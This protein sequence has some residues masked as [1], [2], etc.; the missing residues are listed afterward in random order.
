LASN[1][2]TSMGGTLAA[3]AITVEEMLDRAALQH[4]VCTYG[5]AIDRH[6]Y[7]LLRSLYHSD[8][9][10]DH[11]PYYSGPASGY[12][13]WLPTMMANWSL[14]SHAMTNMV[15][16]IDGNDAEGIVTARAWHRTADGSRDFIAWGRYADR[17]RKVDGIWR[18]QHRFFILE[19]SE[20][21]EVPQGDDFGADGVAVAASGAAD[22]LYQ[23][24]PRIAADRHS[25]T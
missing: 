21:R 3:H 4:L 14:T 2:E 9:T 24:L 7:D 16:L 5:H 6:D 12:I 15:F 23:G 25:R 8:A 1:P 10:D 13:D 18:F 17:Y 20:D 19:S 11:S 22:P